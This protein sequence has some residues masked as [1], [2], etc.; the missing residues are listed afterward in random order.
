MPEKRQSGGEQAIAQSGT[1]GDA[2]AAIVEKGAGTPFG[3]EQFIHD[4]IVDKRSGQLTLAL[5]CD[6]NGE[7]RQAMHEVRGSIERVDDPAMLIVGS[8]D[9]TGFFHQESVSGPRFFQFAMD[10]FLSLAIGRGDKI[11]RPLS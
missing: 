8:V 3:G 2:Q 9:R 10:N 1:L 11:G 5:Q 7:D 6:R 4:R